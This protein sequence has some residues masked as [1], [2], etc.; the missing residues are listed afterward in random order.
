M[1]FPEVG[2]GESRHSL[3]LPIFPGTRSRST[4]LP[5]NAWRTF[6]DRLFVSSFAPVDI[7]PRI[8]P[9]HPIPSHPSE[10]ELHALRLSC[11]EL[12]WLSEHARGYLKAAREAAGDPG[13]FEQE[14]ELAEEMAQLQRRNIANLERKLEQ[15]RAQ[16]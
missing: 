12:E 5:H 8:G 4:I 9:S 2:T 15:K 7:P 6:S 13:I 14:L 1:L 16:A 11:T 3:L 10:K